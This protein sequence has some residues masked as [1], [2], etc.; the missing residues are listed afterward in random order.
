MGKSDY[1]KVLR[2]WVAGLVIVLLLFGAFAPVAMA[3][4]WPRC[5]DLCTAN[6]V[7]VNSMWLEVPGSCTPGDT[8][9]AD[10]WMNLWFNRVNT[11]CIIV[12]ADLYEA[13]DPLES[14]WTSDIIGYNGDDGDH[15]YNMGTVSWTCGKTFEMKNILVMWLQTDPG[16]VGCSGTCT[17]YTTPSKCTKY[18][19]IIVT[20]P[21]VADF[22][23]T[24]VCYCTYTQF[25]DKTTGGVEPY[26]YS[27]DFNNDG[28]YEIVNDPYAANPSYHYDNPGT[29]TAKLRVNDSDSPANTDYQS[30][31]VTVYQNPTAD[32]GG[33]KSIS[34][35]DSVEIGG[36][37]TA[38]GGK[39]PYTYS[40]TP[41]TGLNDTTIANPRASPTSTTTYTV[42]VTD[43]NLCNNTD[44]V[45]VYVLDLRHEIQRSQWKWSKGSG[46]ARSSWLDD[47]Q[48]Q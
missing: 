31:L 1:P 32:A 40:W 44:D 9:T 12:V 16:A 48:R 18:P 46:R 3:Q 34:V 23:A 33:N 25:T 43:A 29:P 20:T 27:W 45:V 36:S 42:S 37:P 7:K 2:R 8:V 13:G 26:N 24:T 17:D 35:G 14:N 41:I 38:S 10:V 21:L 19:S 4:T 47:I 5:V 39:S 11:Y 30:H 6:D 22:E 28:T 15:S